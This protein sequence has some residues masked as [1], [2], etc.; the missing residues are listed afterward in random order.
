MAGK[1]SDQTRARIR[2][3]DLA[4][5]IQELQAAGCESLRAIAAGL[6]ERGIPAPRG[7]NWSAVQVA[8]LLEAAAVPFDASA[9]AAEESSKVLPNR[10]DI[11]LT[12]DPITRNRFGFSKR[13]PAANC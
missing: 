12:S 7:G 8:R 5:T 6:E 2:A 13:Y 1:K 11:Q 10:S 9:E 4:P 3:L